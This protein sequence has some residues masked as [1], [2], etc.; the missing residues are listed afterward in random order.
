MFFS[1]LDE[2]LREGFF[3]CL[4]VC[5]CRGCGWVVTAAARCH[6]T[7]STMWSK[8]RGKVRGERE[9]GRGRGSGG[10]GGGREGRDAS[11]QNISMQSS[12]WCGKDCACLWT[13]AAA[14][15]VGSATS[16]TPTCARARAYTH[17]HISVIS[18]TAPTKTILLS[19]LCQRRIKEREEN[20]TLGVSLCQTPPYIPLL[21]CVSLLVCTQRG[22]LDGLRWN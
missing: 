21:I 8:V 3:F 22:W 10:G 11:C 9:R 16:R 20:W 2:P 14:F 12:Y 18:D 13:A 7:A 19:H 1:F 15:R 4:C 6:F 17:A 5:H